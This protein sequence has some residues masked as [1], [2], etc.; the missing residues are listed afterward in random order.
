MIAKREKTTMEF[1]MKEALIEAERAGAHGDIPVGAIIVQ[2][3]KIIARGRNLRPLCHPRTLSYVRGGYRPGP[4]QDG[5]LR[6]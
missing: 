4:N 6:R 5:G 3:G 1:Y 2:E